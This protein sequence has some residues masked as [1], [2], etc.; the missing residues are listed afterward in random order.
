[1][2]LALAGVFALVVGSESLDEF[3]GDVYSKSLGRLMQPDGS[4]GLVFLLPPGSLDKM[5]AKRKAHRFKPPR[6]VGFPHSRTAER[7]VMKELWQMALDDYV[8]FYMWG[9]FSLSLVY[10]LV[11]TFLQP[12][13]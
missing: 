7:S 12:I 8:H 5:E 13:D 6:R 4:S 3:V 11:R 9:L 2:F 1:M 10:A